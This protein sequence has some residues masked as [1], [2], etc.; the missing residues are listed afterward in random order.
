MS[1]ANSNLG[2]EKVV[3]ALEIPN[4]S[5]EEEGMQSKIVFD[6]SNLPLNTRFPPT[7]ILEYDF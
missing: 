3:L 6:T 4:D 5:P 1:R 7:R 2:F